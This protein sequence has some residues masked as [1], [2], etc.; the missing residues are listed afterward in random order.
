MDPCVIWPCLCR[1]ILGTKDLSSILLLSLSPSAVL[2]RC[3]LVP[4]DVEW[5]G[6]E[7][8]C[9][10]GVWEK[11][12]ARGF[13]SHTSQTSVCKTL[14]HWCSL[15]R[16]CLPS[17]FQV[18]FPPVAPTALHWFKKIHSILYWD[19][20]RDRGGRDG[21]LCGFLI[22]FCFVLPLHL[23]CVEFSKAMN[24]VFSVWGSL[25][26]AYSVFSA[27]FPSSSLISMCPVRCAFLFLFVPLVSQ[28][29]KTKTDGELRAL[30]KGTQQK[31]RGLPEIPP[32]C[33]TMRF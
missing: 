30:A 3:C 22:C 1:E 23:R 19:H 28:T 25:L 17:V 18:C 24:G 7:G 26:F 5:I 21:L 6:Y 12:G 4:S 9:H 32:G 20:S 11:D 27:L 16:V 31:G 33:E 2:C 10:P 14:L 29:P 15:G 8:C 13:C